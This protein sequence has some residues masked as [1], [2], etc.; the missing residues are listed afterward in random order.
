MSMKTLGAILLV[1]G[2]TVGAGILAL[3]AATGPAGFLPG[4][5]ILLLCWAVMTLG[6]LL[7]LEVNFWLPQNSNI[8]SMARSTLGLKGEVAAWIIYLLLLYALVAAYIAAGANLFQGTISVYLPNAPAWLAP[9]CFLAIFGTVIYYGIYIV[10]LVTRGFIAAKFLSYLAI[11][12]TML[13][14]IEFD[15][16]THF[17]PKMLLPTTTI[18]IT[19]FG[20]SSII[21]SLRSYLNND[22]RK[23]R[24][25][26]LVGSLISLFCYILWILAVLGTLPVEGEYGFLAIL[27]S[28]DSSASLVTALRG[29]L[30]KDI[31]TQSANIFTSISVVTS[32]LAVALGLSDF[33]ADGVNIPK[34]GKGNLIIFLL[35]FL[36][37]T[38]IALF[39]PRAFMAC[40]NYGGVLCLLLLVVLP[41]LMAWRGRYLQKKEGQYRMFGGKAFVALTFLSG[42]GLIILDLIYG[43]F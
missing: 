43:K 6:A 13:P 1:V 31:I 30:N 24:F 34:K 16:L 9:L 14:F 17:A 19:S 8:I 21:P 38:L 4:V 11:I 26:I 41:A 42:F 40:L 15:K 20:F 23:L 25:V 28:N 33:L 18:V 36:P 3:P 7:I 32:F 22:V 2:C 27:A 10:D 12:V 35:T 5:G 29:Y 39:Y 37:P